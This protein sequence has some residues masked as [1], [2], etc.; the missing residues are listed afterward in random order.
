MLCLSNN[1]LTA[2]PS[3]IGRL[4]H[5]TML[6]VRWNKLTLTVRPFVSQYSELCPSGHR[7]TQRI[8]AV[9][10]YGAVGASCGVQM[11]DR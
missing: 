6:D 7:P 10:V 1:Q 2:L 11:S 8:R 3:E 4:S 9:S 5:L